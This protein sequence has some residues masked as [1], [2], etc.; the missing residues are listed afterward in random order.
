MTGGGGAASSNNKVGVGIIG[1]GP[2]GENVTRSDAPP[3]PIPQA[4]APVQDAAPDPNALVPNVNAEPDPNELKP[5]VAPNAL[6]APQQVNQIDPNAPQ[7]AAAS[8]PKDDGNEPADVTYSSSKHNKK[9]G[10]RKVIPF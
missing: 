6:P 9:K 4:Q 8:N 1:T 5:N 10:L 2:V 7:N 3:N